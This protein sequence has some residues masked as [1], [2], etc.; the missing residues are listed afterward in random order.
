MKLFACCI[1]CCL[2]AGASHAATVYIWTGKTGNGIYGDQ[3]NWEVNGS[4]N[5]YYPQSGSDSAIIGPDAG[6]I[7]WST[8]QAYFGETNTIQIGPGSTL[9]CVTTQGDFNVN[10]VTLEGNSHLVFESAN[11]FGLK[12]NF[13]LDFGTFTA[14]EHGSWT[15]TDITGFWT[16]GKTVSFT[17]T[18]DMNSLS[19][20]GTI[21]LASI[22][23]SQ[24]GNDLKLDLSGLNITSTSTT[25]AT[26]SQVTE[27]GI[28]KVV[29]NYESIP[30]PAACTLGLLGL[31]ALLLK[32]RRQ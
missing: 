25:Q 20:S 5:S 15:A 22:K 2:L 30:E 9:L 21:E 3:G 29:V 8:S 28:T 14:S 26:V 32:R 6:T 16:N 12:N 13:T 18:L 10:T 19:G 31:G 7:T 11:A 24:L 27:N 23:A 1:L 4:P 17:G